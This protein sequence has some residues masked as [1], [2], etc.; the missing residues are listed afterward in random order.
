MAITILPYDPTVT[1]DERA[2][3]LAADMADAR[4]WAEARHKE[5]IAEARALAA[6][7]NNDISSLRAAAWGQPLS[8]TGNR[9]AEKY[10]LAVDLL[11]RERAVAK[12]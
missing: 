9:E 10:Y 8:P 11:A 5:S 4:L 6:A 3:R 7:H 2:R 12:T 1:D